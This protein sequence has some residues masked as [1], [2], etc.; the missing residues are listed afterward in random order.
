MTNLYQ[1]HPCVDPAVN[2]IFFL[3]VK[4]SLS[5]YWETVVNG[6]ILLLRPLTQNAGSSTAAVMTSTQDISC[7]DHYAVK[8]SIQ[9]VFNSA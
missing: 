9:L 5:Q 2:P 3:N 1:V 6:K 4:E 7:T 8:H